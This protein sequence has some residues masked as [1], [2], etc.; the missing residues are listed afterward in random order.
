M[1]LLDRASIYARAVLGVVI[2]SVRLSPTCFVT[3]PNNAL[4]VFWYHTKGQSL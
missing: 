1:N 2:L 3:K 4:Q